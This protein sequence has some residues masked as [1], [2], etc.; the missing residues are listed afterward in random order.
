MYKKYLF[1]IFPFIMTACAGTLIDSDPKQKTETIA[2][3]SEVKKLKQKIVIGQLSNETR[4]GKDNV[5]DEHQGHLTE[6]TS[7]LLANRLTASHKLLVM[8]RPDIT[9]AEQATLETTHLKGVDTLILG[10]I[11]ESKMNTTKKSDASTSANV[12]T[13]CAKVKLHLVDVKSGDI[14]FTVTGRGEASSESDDEFDN[15]EDIDKNLNQ[16]ALKSALKG[17]NKLLIVKLKERPWHTDI[18]KIQGKQIF[19]ASGKHQG[20]DP[21]DILAVMEQTDDS[22]QRYQSGFLRTPKPEMIGK[23]RVVSVFGDNE[24]NEGAVT[25]LISGTAHGTSPDNTL[26]ISAIKE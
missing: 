13:A 15:E 19:I 5:F 21:G 6:K 9:K 20:I 2:T 25:E 11:I 17:L 8:E 12:Q 23:V 16:R 22:I 14:F 1:L 18:L 24:S 4:Y 3:L 26:F 10:S 7:R